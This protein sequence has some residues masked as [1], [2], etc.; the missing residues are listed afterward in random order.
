M[1]EGEGGR[2]GRR[3]GWRVRLAELRRFDSCHSAV[4][5]VF[6]LMVGLANGNETR[7]IFNGEN[8]DT[9]ESKRLC[10]QIDM[11]RRRCAG[12]KPFTRMEYQVLYIYIYVRRRR[13]RFCE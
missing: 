12:Q 9:M 5:R 11:H 1:E 4:N 2:F 10:K 7:P 8:T 3:V 13:G 6:M